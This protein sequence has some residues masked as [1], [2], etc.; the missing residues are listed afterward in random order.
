[1]SSGAQFPS[2]DLMW[3]TQHH[4]PP[5]L[6]GFN[7]RNLETS[8]IV[9]G[10]GNSTLPHTL[11]QFNSCYGNL[12][13]YKSW[14]S[15]SQNWLLLPEGTEKVLVLTPELEWCQLKPSFCL[16]IAREILEHTQ[17]ITTIYPLM[18]ITNKLLLYELSINTIYWF[19]VLDI[20]YFL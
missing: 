10:F 12:P 19:V 17:T 6:H 2:N 11:R 16:R 8:R 3:W 14:F 18:T 13:I 15:S 1:V 5:I 9:Q 20:L 4:K 7:L